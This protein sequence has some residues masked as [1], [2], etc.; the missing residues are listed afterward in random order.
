MSVETVIVVKSLKYIYLTY[1]YVKDCL[2]MC[3][4]PPCPVC[5]VQLS[6]ILWKCAEC[7]CQPT[8][9]STIF[10]L[11]EVTYAWLYISLCLISQVHT[12]SLQFQQTPRDKQFTS[13]MVGWCVALSCEVHCTVAVTANVSEVNCCRLC[14]TAHVNLRQHGRQVTLRHRWDWHAQCE[15]RVNTRHQGGYVV[16]V[17]SYRCYRSLQQTTMWSK[18]ASCEEFRP[19]PLQAHRQTHWLH[20]RP[21]NTE[22]AWWGA[23]DVG[24][25]DDDNRG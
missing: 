1:T 9:T 21:W 14:F 10:F 15:Q 12:D 20:T 8:A 3:Y 2:M 23:L 5:M 24:A 6:H 25:R 18:M 7:W 4:T 13:F 17:F 22:L 19:S 11:S 16:V